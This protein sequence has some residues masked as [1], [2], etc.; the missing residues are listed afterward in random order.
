VAWLVKDITPKDILTDIHYWIPDEQ[1]WFWAGTI[2]LIL[3]MVWLCSIFLW[4]GMCASCEQK[5]PKAD[6]ELKE[7]LLRKATKV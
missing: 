3:V 5:K 1:F 6:I 4:R 2:M 7:D